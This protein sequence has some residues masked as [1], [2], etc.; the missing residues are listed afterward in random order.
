MACIALF[1]LL[2]QPKLLPAILICTY[3]FTYTYIIYVE[4]VLLLF[5]CSLTFLTF[6]LL[7]LSYF[8]LF[9]FF[10]CAAHNTDYIILTSLPLSLNFVLH[11]AHT[12]TF[13]SVS[14]YFSQVIA[15]PGKLES[16]QA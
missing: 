8:F 2:S 11:D 6:F 10:S 12:R 5:F 16:A 9:L 3:A 13:L 7:T 1:D 4:L 15:S 14:L